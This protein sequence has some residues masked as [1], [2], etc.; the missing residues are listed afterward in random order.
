MK[1][2]MGVLRVG[3]SG[4]WD[5]CCGSQSPEYSDAA[6]TQVGVGN[7]GHWS[8]IHFRMFTVLA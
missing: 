7:R 5:Y 8:T 2:I 6:D 1:F 4:V 3:N